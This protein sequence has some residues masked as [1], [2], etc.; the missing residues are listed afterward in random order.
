MIVTA[1]VGYIPTN[2]EFLKEWMIRVVESVNMKVINGPHVCYSD[3]KDNEG[4]TGV[5]V[6]DFSHIAIHTWPKDSLIEFDLFSCKDFDVSTVI[7]ELKY[8][9][10]KDYTV[11]IINRDKKFNV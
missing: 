3:V 11:K 8:F 2:P 5:A 1:K 4:W 7:E 9:E 10:L 6:L